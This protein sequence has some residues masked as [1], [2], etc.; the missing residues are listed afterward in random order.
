MSVSVKGSRVILQHRCASQLHR[1]SYLMQ[2]LGHTFTSAVTA[3]DK[4]IVSVRRCAQLRALA[5]QTVG[6]L[7]QLLRGRPADR[8]STT[9][10]RS[11]YRLS[12]DE[13][14]TRK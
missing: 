3:T 2:H 5:R 14:R 7:R 10:T 11:T 1:R 13:C 8:S 4:T 6:T 12:Q 9:R